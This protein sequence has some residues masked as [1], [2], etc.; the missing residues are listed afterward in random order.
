MIITLK[1]HKL[2]VAGLIFIVVFGSIGIVGFYNNQK[3]EEEIIKMAK[4][5]I[6][7][8]VTKK[9]RQLN[10]MPIQKEKVDKREEYKNM[11]REIKE[12]KVVG[13]LQI[14]KIDLETYILAETNKKS[15]EI[16]VTK[17]CGPQIN[18]T[19]NFCIAGHN[20]YNKK[21]FNKIK[22]LE[23]KDTIIVTD[24]YDNS[25]TY[26]VYDNFQTSSDDVSC[27]SQETQNEREITLITCTLGAVKRVIIKAVEVY[28]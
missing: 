5:D 15:L 2:F 19:G 22:K 17:L 6:K 20:Y 9:G 1:L 28:D 12:N 13:K 4:I 14:P 8:N 21:M 16:S 3:T 7:T 24:T 25:V 23:I 11:P 10:K 26:E 18:E 27:L